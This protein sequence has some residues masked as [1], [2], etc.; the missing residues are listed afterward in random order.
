M[1]GLVLADRVDDQ[2]AH[3]VESGQSASSSGAQSARIGPKHFSS[4]ARIIALPPPRPLQPRLPACLY[5]S[6]SGLASTTPLTDTN[7]SSVVFVTKG[8]D[9]TFTPDLDSATLDRLDAYAE[10]FRDL[11]NRPRQA[12]W[13]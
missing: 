4:M 9:K 2:P 6:R 3:G 5:T 7:R 8:M 10:R 11:F 13:C 1:D 12:A